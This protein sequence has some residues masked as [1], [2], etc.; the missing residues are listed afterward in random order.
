MAGVFDSI[1]PSP[2]VR[3]AAALYGS[4]KARSKREACQAVGLNPAYLTLLRDNP[5]VTSIVEEAAHSVN[6]QTKDAGALLAQLGRRALKNIHTIME[7]GESE[8]NRLRAAI[9]LADR[10][11]ETGKIIKAHVTSFNIDAGDASKLASAMVE[12]ARAKAQWASEVQDGF[13]RVADPSNEPSSNA[14]GE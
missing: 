6:F 5:E 4:G 10:S 11:P 8:A 13:V 14:G 12:A 3:L 9:D 2:R 1:R 7:D